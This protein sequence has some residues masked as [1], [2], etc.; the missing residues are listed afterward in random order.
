MLRTI[1]SLRHSLIFSFYSRFIAHYS[2]GINLLTRVIFVFLPTILPY[3]LQ[4]CITQNCAFE[5]YAVL[6]VRDRSI[7]IRLINFILIK[8]ARYR[9]GVA[10]SICLF[11]ALT[12]RH[13][14]TQFYILGF[15]VFSQAGFFKMYVL[16]PTVHSRS[17]L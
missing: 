2:Y 14:E 6:P 12:L 4:E 9:T 17:I 16:L 11:F 10:L 8:F 7:L 1:Q 15:S 3:F 13:F 5:V